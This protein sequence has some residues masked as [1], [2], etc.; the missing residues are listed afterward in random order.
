MWI[1]IVSIILILL[2]GIALFELRVRRPDQIVLYESDGVVKQRRTRI[3]ARHFNLA[4]N[5]TIVSKS[6]NFQCEARGKLLLNVNL[7]VSLAPDSRRLTELVRTGGWE[8]NAVANAAQE[9]SALL[10][11]GIKQY[12]EEKEMEQIR[13]EA[14]SAHLTST[15]GPSLTPFGLELIS[16]N[17][18]SVDPV[19]TSITEA[20][21]QQESSRIMEQT[22][23]SKQQ[24][25]IMAA[26]AKTEA[27]EQIA[28]SEHNLSMHRLELKQSEQAKQSELE[29]KETEEELKRRQMR[30]EFDRNEMELLNKH[31]ELLLLTPQAARLAEASQ[32]LKNARTVVSLSPKDVEHGAGILETLQ[33]YLQQ[34]VKNPQSKK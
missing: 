12:S 13:S 17:V 3:Y 21:Q 28:L 25:R 6:L 4:M 34:I 22:E 10:L 30:L 24:A 26:R 27:E 18:Q 29:R 11:S 33:S 16:L 15:I 32:S 19:D 14:L 1:V 5:G 31:R 7:F 8:T 2:I 20:L 9:V 23:K